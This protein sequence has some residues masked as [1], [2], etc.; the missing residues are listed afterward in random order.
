MFSVGTH[1]LFYLDPSSRYAC[2]TLDNVANMKCRKKVRA[3]SVGCRTR[4]STLRYN[5]SFSQRPMNPTVINFQHKRSIEL[6]KCQSFL[7]IMCNIG[8]TTMNRNNAI[9]RK[10]EKYTTDI[11]SLKKVVTTIQYFLIIVILITIWDCAH[12]NI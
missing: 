4:I 1:S 9:M 8:K 12:G 3:F 10:L 11:V 6:V 2:Y 7:C 5:N